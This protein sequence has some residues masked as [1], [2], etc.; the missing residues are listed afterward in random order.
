MVDIRTRARR[1]LLAETRKPISEL[2]GQIYDCAI[3]PAL[4]EQTLIDLVKMLDCGSA[5][6]SLNDLQHDHALIRKS[7][8]WER[9]WLDERQKHLPEIHKAL[10]RWWAQSP[11]EDEPFVASRELSSG[12]LEASPYVRNCLGPLGITDVA[13]FF[14][15][16]TQSHFSELVLFRNAPLGAIDPD[17]I[18]IARVLLPH[19]RRAVTISQLL[20]VKTL[21]CATMERVIDALAAPVLLVNDELHI[22]HANSA[23]RA[24]LN[25]GDAIFSQN[26]RLT[27][28]DA[29]ADT[30]L[31]AAVAQ[32]ASDEGAFGR[33]GLGLPLKSKNG[34]N[35]VLNVLSLR[36][37]ARRSRLMPGATAAIFIA[38]PRSAPPTAS[39][40]LKSLF[41]LT[42]AEGAVLDLVVSG[43][44]NA[45][46]AR[47]L[48]ITVATTKTHLQH[49][50]DKTGVRRQAE[51]V[52]LVA[53]F[54]PPL[55]S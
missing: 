7:T 27:A 35:L 52:R 50:F 20:D 36:H 2:I 15:M 25:S 55:R 8:G 3:D 11:P 41:D 9:R 19:L 44:T 48:G 39:D 22:V 1:P 43:R 24:L 6:L 18:E 38:S 49:I 32:A 13:H 31:A 51:L 5:I 42:P 23:A 54:A 29:R 21:A 10:S 14:L 12:D 46:T 53:S 16:R 30:A 26:G 45:H 34:P 4:W 47:A 33:K 17:E 37:G 28:G 40:A